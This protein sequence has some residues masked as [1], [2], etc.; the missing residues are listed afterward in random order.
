MV[1]RHLAEMHPNTYRALESLGICTIDAGGEGNIADLAKLYK[2][3]GK[4]T[5]ALCDKQPDPARLLI[6]GQVQQLYMH[7][8]DGLENLVLKNTTPAAMLRFAQMI[9]WPPH[10]SVKYS[11][12]DSSVQDALFEYFCGT[13]AEWGIADFLA[14]CTEDEIPQWL[15]D[16]CK[17]LAFLCD[18]P[19]PPPIPPSPMAPVPPPPSQSA[20]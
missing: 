8:E 12:P 14:Q 5:F 7:P 15:R 20:P 9:V 1:C 4:T 6:E 16:A 13:K 3:I 2:D 10:L 18:P 19:P 17:S 11:A